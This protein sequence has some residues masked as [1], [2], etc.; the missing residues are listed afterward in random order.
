[1]LQRLSGGFK[2]YVSGPLL[3]PLTHEN[4]PI[5]ILQGS[6]PAGLAERAVAGLATPKTISTLN[7]GASLIGETLPSALSTAAI[8]ITA[9]NA[10]DQL[11]TYGQK[12]FT[13]TTDDFM[14]GL[15]ERSFQNPVW[16]TLD[17]GVDIAS[18][19]IESVP[20]LARAGLRQLGK[21]DPARVTSHNTMKGSQR[22]NSYYKRAFC[23]GLLKEAQ[24][25]S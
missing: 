19:P 12:G 7:S 20:S 21:F 3:N 2:D 9:L 8:P 11:A 18:R 10:A 16:N 13:K 4:S 15:K 14:A 23:N 5:N 24:A 17:K 25:R 1:M 6:K 22:L